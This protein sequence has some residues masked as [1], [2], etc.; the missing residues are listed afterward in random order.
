MPF[1]NLYNFS[2]ALVEL[3]LRLGNRPVGADADD[4]AASVNRYSQW[5]NSAQ[6]RI[7]GCVI[8]TPDIDVVAFPMQTVNGQS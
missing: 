7:A 3:K 2:E 8:E 5:L 4:D 6:M 1:N